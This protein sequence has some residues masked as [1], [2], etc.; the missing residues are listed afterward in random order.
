MSK[1]ETVTIEQIEQDGIEL[2]PAARYELEH[3]LATTVVSRTVVNGDEHVRYTHIRKG[4]S[5][6]KLAERQRQEN[7]AQTVVMDE[8]E[9][10]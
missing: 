1:Y 7:E 8:E 9:E 6:I 10:N 3:G 4:P 2:P 5:L